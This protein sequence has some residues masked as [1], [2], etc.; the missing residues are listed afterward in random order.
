MHRG[1]RTKTRMHHTDTHLNHTHTHTP[2][3]ALS[4]EPLIA[5]QART[6]HVHA[7]TQARTHAG[8]HARTPSPF[9]MLDCQVTITALIHIARTLHTHTHSLTHTHKGFVDTLTVQSSDAE[10]MT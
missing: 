10:A 5:K 8:T 4:V 3:S 1:D 7:T 9:S 6:Q 2:T